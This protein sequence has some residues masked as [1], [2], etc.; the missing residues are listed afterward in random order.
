MVRWAVLL[1]DAVVDGLSEALLLWG[2]D[3]RLEAGG[4]LSPLHCNENPIY[5]FTEKENWA[6]SVPV[7]KFM[8]L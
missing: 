6:A 5:V 4:T 7:S 2:V 3:G 8:C 1:T